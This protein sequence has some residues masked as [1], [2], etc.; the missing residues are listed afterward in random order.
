MLR[1]FTSGARDLA[2]GSSQPKMVKHCAPDSLR[3]ASLAK[4]LARLN[5]TGFDMTPS[6]VRGRG[7][8]VIRAL[9]LVGPQRGGLGRQ[10]LAPDGGQLPLWN[11]NEISAASPFVGFA[12]FESSRWYCTLA[13]LK[14]LKS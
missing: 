12:K 2:W 8:D 10:V 4:A 3:R 7:Q 11:R 13:A 9:D 5:S 1:A 14:R 6:A